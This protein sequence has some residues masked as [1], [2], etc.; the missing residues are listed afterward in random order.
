MHIKLPNIFRIRC[1]KRKVCKFPSVQVDVCLLDKGHQS[2]ERLHPFLE[3]EFQFFQCLLGILRTEN[4]DSDI[5]VCHC[6][7]VKTVARSS[8]IQQ[9]CWF[10][11]L[12]LCMVDPTPPHG[13]VQ[14]WRLGFCV[15]D[16][17]LV[18]HCFRLCCE[19]SNVGRFLAH[20]HSVEHLFKASTRCSKLSTHERNVP[21]RTNE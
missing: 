20:R 9:E 1:N 3:T 5:L 10:P 19:I 16:K 2:I 6:D 13:D 18:P 7:A 8:P 14:Q 21:L 17:E 11:T 12:G 4:R 15:C